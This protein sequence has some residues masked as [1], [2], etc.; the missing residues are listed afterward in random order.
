MEA[1]QANQCQATTINNNPSIRDQYNY[2][3]RLICCLSKIALAHPNL[4]SSRN[5]AQ[6]QARLRLDS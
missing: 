6:I 1:L 5:P 4:Q 2:S 3:D